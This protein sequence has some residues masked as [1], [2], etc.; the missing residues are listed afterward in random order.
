MND[1]QLV[2]YL[3][4]MGMTCFVKYFYEFSDESLSSRYLIDLLRR[5]EGYTEGSCRTRVSRA[6]Q[7]IQTGRARDALL[8]I[9]K[10]DRISHVAGQ[11][12]KIINRD[13]TSNVKE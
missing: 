13:N 9:S 6:R 8:I 4:K 2:E 3:R 7:I 1:E 10:S 5:K 12:K 11:A